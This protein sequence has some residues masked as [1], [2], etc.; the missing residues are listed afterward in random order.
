MIYFISDLHLSPKRPEIT[1]AFF[2]FLNTTAA[3]A[4]CLYILGDFFD[5]W[6]G[7]DDD[8]PIFKE[9]ELALKN[10]NQKSKNNQRVYFMHGNRDFLV[11][12]DFIQR[13]G[14]TLLNDPT[15]IQLDGIDTLL[16]HGDSLCTLD[17][18]YMRFRALVRDPEWQQNIKQ[19]SLVERK[20]IATQM[21]ST[22][23]SMNSLK[24]DDIMD[25]T[26]SEV[27]SLMNQYQTPLLIHGHT[28][29][30]ERHSVTLENKTN[31][32]RIVLGD[33]GEQ[34]WYLRAETHTEADIKE[35]LS[36]NSFTIEQ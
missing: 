20:A 1:Q 13:T 33:W 35:S 10:F 17:Q 14:I 19:K 28:H 36:L 4:E 5:A 27:L 24:A 29:R 11:G 8:T 15:V 6:V 23:Q 12:R 25:V 22:S 31:G 7:D 3:N 34:G 21:R 30:P 26:P 32:E 18:E 9:V 16:M 2:N